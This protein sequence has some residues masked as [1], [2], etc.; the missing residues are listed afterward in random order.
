MEWRW[1]SN[2]YREEITRLVLSTS[3]KE[4]WKDGEIK[5]LEEVLREYQDATPHKRDQMWFF[6][7]DLR[8]DF[9]EMERS[10]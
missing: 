2:Q 9:D 4:Y 8:K 10:E 3:L 5:S 7:V 6:Y 1:I